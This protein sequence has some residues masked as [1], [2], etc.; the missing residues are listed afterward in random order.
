MNAH[1]IGLKV[2]GSVLAIAALSSLSGCVV[3]A[4]PVRARTVY[5]EPARPVVVVQPARTVYVRGY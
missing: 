1:K 2:L 3:T 4:R 5:V